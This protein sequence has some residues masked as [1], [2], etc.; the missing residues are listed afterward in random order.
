M[1][2]HDENTLYHRHTGEGWLGGAGCAAHGKLALLAATGPRTALRHID[3]L[4][5][6]IPSPGEASRR[7][8]QT[9]EALQRKHAHRER[10]RSSTH[11]MCSTRS[12]SWPAAHRPAP[13]A[14][15]NAPKLHGCPALNSHRSRVHQAQSG[16][17][18]QKLQL[19]RYPVSNCA[20]SMANNYTTF[21]GVATRPVTG[22]RAQAPCHW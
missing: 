18:L 5:A 8:L 19:Y 4:A 10:L 16:P 7:D 15:C 3:G 9:P 17:V 2:A 14:Q 13:V 11:V 6:A 20:F 22:S 12:A 1:R 21:K